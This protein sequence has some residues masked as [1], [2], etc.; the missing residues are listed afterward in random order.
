MF[1]TKK[2]V[3]KCKFLIIT[4]NQKHNYYTL[5]I[6]MTKRNYPLGLKTY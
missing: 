6:I 4:A 2:C 1:L 5:Y 3:N